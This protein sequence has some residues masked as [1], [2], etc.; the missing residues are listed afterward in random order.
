MGK[1]AL[2]KNMVGIFFLNGGGVNT[3]QSMQTGNREKCK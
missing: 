1:S 3:A 2:E